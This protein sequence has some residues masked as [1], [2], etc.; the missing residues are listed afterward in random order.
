MYGKSQRAEKEH[1]YSERKVRGKEEILLK[2]GERNSKNETDLEGRMLSMQDFMHY[3]QKSWIRSDGKRQEVLR[4]ES[5]SVKT[6]AF[7]LFVH[8]RGEM[9]VTDLTRAPGIHHYVS[10][11]PDS[12]PSQ[13]LAN[14]YGIKIIDM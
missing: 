5:G 13:P 4:E 2:V 12:L 10:C 11:I 14:W 6:M 3:R 7:V 9:Q 1:H 8:L